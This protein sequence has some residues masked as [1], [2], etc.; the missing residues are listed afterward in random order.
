MV[1]VFYLATLVKTRTKAIHALRVYE[2]SHA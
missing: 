2:D 1:V